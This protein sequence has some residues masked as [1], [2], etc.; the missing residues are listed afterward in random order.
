MQRE[1]KFVL[2]RASAVSRASAF[3][4]GGLRHGERAVLVERFCYSG[5][6]LLRI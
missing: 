4:E 5:E 3:S 2:V 6:D 1:S